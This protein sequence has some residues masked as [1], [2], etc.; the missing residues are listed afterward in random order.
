MTEQERQMLRILEKE[1]RIC[2]DDYKESEKAHAQMKSKRD[3]VN[4]SLA[5]YQKYL[6]KKYG[7]VAPSG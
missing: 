1:Q 6:E 7:N 2:E 5:E 4:R 3:A